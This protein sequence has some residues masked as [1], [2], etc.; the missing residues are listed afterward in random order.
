MRMPRRLIAATLTTLSIMLSACGED[1]YLYWMASTEDGAWGD[2]AAAALRAMET[3]DGDKSKSTV[4]DVKA[5]EDYNEETKLGTYVNTYS[6]FGSGL[7]EG[8]TFFVEFLRYNEAGEY[9]H[10]EYLPGH[11]YDELV[12]SRA[13]VM[14]Y[15][16]PTGLM[17]GNAFNFTVTPEP[18]SGL[19]LLLGLAAVGLKRRQ[20]A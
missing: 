6:V 11:S 14:D 18:S 4:I 13:L 7:Y 10:S 19:M 1:S 17:A 5:P 9:M 16:I 8:W 15:M 2:F 3:A 12:R 20:G